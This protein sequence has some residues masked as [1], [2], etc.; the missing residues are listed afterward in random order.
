MHANSRP[1]TSNQISIS[2]HLPQRLA[3]HLVSPFLKPIAPYN[4]LAFD[5]AIAAW[6]QAGSLPLILDSGCGVGLSTLN[7]AQLFPSSFVIGVDQS[8]ERLSRQ[9]DWKGEIPHNCIRVRGDLVDF[10]RLM[11]DAGVRLSRHYVFYPNPWPKKQHLGRRWHGHPVFPFMLSL[12]GEFECRSNWRIYVEECAAA[13]AQLTGV[14]IAAEA[15]QPGMNEGRMAE[16]ERAVGEPFYMT[17]FEKKYSLS[18]HAL[19]RCRAP[20]PLKKCS[21]L[22]LSPRFNVNWHDT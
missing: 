19:W 21:F 17:P 4:R 2:E 22:S 18:G 7:L 10:W 8:D 16:G 13:I 14:P 20:L 15:Y 5:A 6:Q 9:I 11:R 1:V 3:R 12:G